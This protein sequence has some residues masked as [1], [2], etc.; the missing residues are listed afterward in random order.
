MSSKKTKEETAYTE[1]EGDLRAVLNNMQLAE[2]VLDANGHMIDCNDILLDIAGWEREEVIGLNWFDLFLPPDTL[3]DIKEI[4]FKTIENTEIPTYYENEILTRSGERKLIAWTNT[5]VYDKNK[6]ISS[7]ISVGE[8]I[9]ERRSTE[10]SLLISEGQFHTLV[11]TLPDL[12]WLKDI[13][14]VFL[15]CNSKFERLFGA[16]KEDIVGK[17][18]YDFLDK[19]LADFFTQKD[20]EA[21]EAGKP[22]I[23]EEEVIYADDGHKEYLETIKSPMYDQNGHIIG[24]LGV[25]RD[26]TER[27]RSEEDSKRR[28]THL[29]TAQKV[30]RFGSWYFD[31]NTGIAEASD[32]A[33]RIYG[34]NNAHLTIKEIQTVPL[35]DERQMLDKAMKDLITGKASYDVQFRI[36]RQ[37]DG[38]IRYI[39]SV[40]EYFVDKNLVIGTIHDITE[41]KL[42]EIELH[43]KEALL[44][45]V[46]RIAMIGG[47]QF[48]VLS[49][50]STIT[51]EISKI[52]DTEPDET[53][54]EY[55]LAFFPDG[56]RNKIERAFKDTIEKGEAYD[57]ELEFVSAKGK[58]KWV[59]AGG[60]PIIESGKVTTV[61][62]FLQDI[63]ERK[64]QREKLKKM[65]LE[66][67]YLSKIQTMEL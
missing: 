7:V 12:V 35:A 6:N 23:N 27:K 52:R 2:V 65:P 14:G 58:H 3:D 43:K 51:S 36:K 5:A 18:D 32:E 16:K 31:L 66:N 15:T 22:I 11:D 54:S 38:E 39:H 40:A 59:R 67:V 1:Q 55:G 47:W 42:A 41:Q 56:S 63:T 29:R 37:N 19:Q 45:E 28:E 10:R 20:K 48:D 8:D 61:I 26:I 62:G 4:F 49:G 9:T 13:N 44:N 53:V 21:L 64:K 33:Q 34:L 24:I 25:G 46:G 57:L 50:E 60:S 17:T 30:G